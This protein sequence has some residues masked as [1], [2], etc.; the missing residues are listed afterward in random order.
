M[1][2]Y[3]I[4]QLSKRHSVGECLCA[5]PLHLRRET[6]QALPYN[7]PCYFVKEHEKGLL[8]LALFNLP[9]LHCFAL[10]LDKSEHLYYPDSKLTLVLD[11]SVISKKL[12]LNADT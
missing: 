9:V 1:P 7:Y 3:I 2:F 5:L 11:K 10:K 6:T 8:L 4:H 12:L